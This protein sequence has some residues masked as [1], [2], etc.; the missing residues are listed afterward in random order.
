MGSRQLDTFEQQG[1]RRACFNNPT[2]YFDE[3]EMLST[4]SCQPTKCESRDGSE[5]DC[6]EVCEIPETDTVPY[7]KMVSDVTSIY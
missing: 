3:V 5:F 2:K 4:N 1:S 6:T 7:V